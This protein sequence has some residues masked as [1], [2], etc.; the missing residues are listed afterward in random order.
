MKIKISIIDDD[1]NTYEGVMT[2]KKNQTSQNTNIEH[3][4]QKKN[5]IREGSTSGKISELISEGFFD[6]N[7]TISDIV[8]ELKTQDYHF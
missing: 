6:H 1:G 2:L 5:L 4:V 8:A 7:R 3:S